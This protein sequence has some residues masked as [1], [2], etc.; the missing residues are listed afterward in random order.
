MAKKQWIICGECEYFSKCKAGQ[1]KME[2]I[3]PDSKIYNDIGCFNFEQYYF[4]TQ[5]RQLK[6]F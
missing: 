2:N 4:L 6:L 5:D 3:S 1:L